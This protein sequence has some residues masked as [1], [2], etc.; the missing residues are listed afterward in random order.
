MFVHN[1]GAALD[2]THIGVLFALITIL[3][4]FAVIGSV[5][6]QRWKKA[7]FLRVVLFM[8][9]F[10]CS[11]FAVVGP[12][13][14][15]AH[16]DFTIHMIGHLLLGMLGPFLIV[17]GAPMTFVLRALPI[18]WA[19]HVTRLLKSRPLQF[20]SHPIIAS[21]LNIGGLW[22]LYTTHLFAFMHEQPFL[23]FIIHLHVFLAGY[24]I[25]ISIIYIDPTPHRYPFMFRA[26][27]LV[28]S[29]AGHSVLSK[30][31]YAHPPIGVSRADAET[32]AM[33]MYYGGDL[34]DLGII[35]IFCYQWFRATR[36][37]FVEQ[38]SG[39]TETSNS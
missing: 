27:V 8:I 21:L 14:E 33:L 39:V 28:C 35:L 5:R 34:I 37:R 24:V 13:A 26:I 2:G 7:D 25:T 15:R 38:E 16:D 9:G 11:A 4:I 18:S 36:P 29:L 6:K 3:Y 31:V 32:G 19:R 1:H 20:F 12:L 22:V 10:I 30:Y 17:L 23:H